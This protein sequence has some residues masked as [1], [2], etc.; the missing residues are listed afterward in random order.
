MADT[1]SQ[2]KTY[3]SNNMYEKYSHEPLKEKLNN[4]IHQIAN[5]F[6]NIKFHMNNVSCLLDKNFYYDN[7]ALKYCLNHNFDDLEFIEEQ[8]DEIFH[9]YNYIKCYLNEA[10]KM[11]CLI[12]KF[13]SDVK[14][15][16]KPGE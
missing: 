5:K 1:T 6:N 11:K 9:K 10:R 8:F 14:E 4:N 3:T 13:N 16:N 7:E 12:N 15:D 2:H